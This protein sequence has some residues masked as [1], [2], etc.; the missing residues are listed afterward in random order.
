MSDHKTKHC[1]KGCLQGKIGTNASCKAKLLLEEKQYTRP[2]E[3]MVV[4]T[5]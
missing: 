4:K 2:E 3:G 5:R 1:C